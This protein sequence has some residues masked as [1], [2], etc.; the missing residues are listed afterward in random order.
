MEKLEL[1]MPQE[2]ND[3][4]SRILAK[5]VY[6]SSYVHQRAIAYCL[7]LSCIALGGGIIGLNFSLDTTS[8]LA[9]AAIVAGVTL[10]TAVF[11]FMM[12]PCQCGKRP[13]L[14]AQCR[15][16]LIKQ[17][18]KRHLGL[19]LLGGLAVGLAWNL[20]I[21]GLMGSV[22]LSLGAN[23]MIAMAIQCFQS[24]GCFV[25]GLGL[26]TFASA[27][28]NK[29]EWLHTNEVIPEREV[30]K[31]AQ[32]TEETPDELHSL[33]DFHLKAGNIATAERLSHKLLTVLESHYHG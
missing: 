27:V 4:E 21:F 14:T 11:G 19:L 24:T 9:F 32:L 7:G 26:V 29:T 23:A 10:Q 22:G 8:L 31:V 2:L 33:I 17:Q 13:V 6:H 15:S 1:T 20:S 5:A 18:S 16:H 3:F 28:L 25:L 30:Q 12:I